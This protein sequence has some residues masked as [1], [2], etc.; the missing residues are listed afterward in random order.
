MGRKVER[1]VPARAVV[2]TPELSERELT[3]RRNATWTCAQCG[4]RVTAKR[5]GDLRRIAREHA[6]THV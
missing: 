6:A 2:L 3:K 1:A 5:P 4:M